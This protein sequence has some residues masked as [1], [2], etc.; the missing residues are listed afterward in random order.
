MVN[1]SKGRKPTGNIKWK[2]G[3]SNILGKTTRRE[4]ILKKAR[5]AIS[6]L[7]TLAMLLGLLLPAGGAFAAS[8]NRVDRVVSIADDF[9]GK[10]GNKITIAEDSDYPADF[11]D[12]QSF[13]LVLPSGVKWNDDTTV[14]GAVY[15]SKKVNDQIFEV[16]IGNTTGQKDDIVINPSI[17]VDGAT[18]DIR[19][20][21]DQRESGVTTGEVLLARVSGGAS[22]AVA[23]SVETIGESGKTGTIQIDE[24]S[25]GS[26][27]EVEKI[28]LKLPSNFKWNATET[29]VTFGGGF[30]S[31]KVTDKKADGRNLD[32]YVEA[33][34]TTSQRGTIYITPFI[35]AEKSAKYGE[36]EINISGTEVDDA[37]IVV[38]EYADFGLKLE[39]KEVKERVAGIFNA[40]TEELTIE[41]TVAGTLV[42]GRKVNLEFPS[43][44]KVT[45]VTQGTHTGIKIKDLSYDCTDNEVEFTIDEASKSGTV[46]KIKLKFEL[47]IKADMT[48]D[49]EVSLS[50]KSGATGSI[51]VA[52]AVSPASI[53]ASSVAQV[54][55]GVQGQSIGDIIIKE[56]KSEAFEK[57]DLKVELPDNIEWTSKPTVEVIEGNG[58]IDKDG[59]STSDNVLTIPIKNTSS[60]VTAIKIS[61]IKVDINR[62][63]PEGEVVAK[64]KGK[65]IVRNHKDQLGYYKGTADVVDDDGKKGSSDVL[66]PGEF[67]QS[68]ASKVVVANV[69][70]P[71]PEAGTVVFNI[72]S[73]I[74]TAGGVTKVMDAAPYIKDGR[75]YVPVR[76]MAL[77][78]GVNESDIAF[79]NGVVTLVKG[80]TTL[81]LTIGSKSLVSN[82]STIEMDVAPEIT[83]GR[84]MLPA[85]FVAEAFGAIV[86]FA[87]G[88]VV[89]SQ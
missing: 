71:A 76:Y 48:G 72:G 62:I 2:S 51:V 45:N 43:W 63:V 13:R 4:F 56:N 86:G 21:I 32:I 79:E 28:T 88:Q 85:R 1:F 57:G 68:T 52:K 27:G 58:E 83:D 54:R 49:V 33:T 12:D 3:H 31:A 29:E 81:Q 46:G 74:Y 55:I 6:I 41:E 87:N 80:D 44:V 35:S 75:T 73:T 16:V 65:S 5:K 40:K 20:Q 9:N 22:T 82:D 77:A 25:L 67:D 18:G 47:S 70:T 19:V 17:E 50:G 64:L 36:V 37:D 78:M 61:N 42:Q 66:D 15:S 30:A 10:L 84:T 89:I 24:T 14:S 38:A 34:K 39:I 59:I 60:K 26:L 8:V 11:E 53:N 23:L 69:V 7:V